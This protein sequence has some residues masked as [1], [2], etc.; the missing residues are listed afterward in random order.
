MDI[1]EQLGA[2]FSGQFM[3]PEI[4]DKRLWYRIAGDEGIAYAVAG[5]AP[6]VD[7]VEDRDF[8]RHVDFMNRTRRFG[9]LRDMYHGAVINEVTIVTG[10]GC[11]MSASGYLD[12]TD[13]DVFQTPEACADH[14]LNTYG[15]F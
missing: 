4:T 13:W 2:E 7:P 11:R 3:Q 10:Y 9:I 12:C 1:M 8:E 6:G 15:S 5:Y 14:L